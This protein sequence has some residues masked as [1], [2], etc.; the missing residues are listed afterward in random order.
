MSYKNSWRPS[1]QGQGAALASISS[2]LLSEL[3]SVYVIVQKFRELS[4]CAFFY[5]NLEA[6][7][8]R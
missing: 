8:S 2:G 3:V 1:V 7:A 4:F 6:T 5:A